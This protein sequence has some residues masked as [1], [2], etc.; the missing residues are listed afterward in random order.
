LPI[1]QAQE[2]DGSPKINSKAAQRKI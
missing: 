1:A 2:G